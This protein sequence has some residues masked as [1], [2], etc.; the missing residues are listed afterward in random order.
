MPFCFKFQH[1]D[2]KVEVAAVLRFCQIL[3]LDVLSSDGPIVDVVVDELVFAVSAVV[4]DLN[5]KVNLVVQ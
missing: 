5:G 1:N 3:G 4:G 2:L